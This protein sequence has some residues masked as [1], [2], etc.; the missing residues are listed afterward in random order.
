MKMKKSVLR[1]ATQVK[2]NAIGTRGIQR[3]KRQLYKE[4]DKYI[5]ILMPE[6]ADAD[7]RFFIRDFAKHLMDELKK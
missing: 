7:P 3:V 6:S 4:V 1:G 5:K 2:A